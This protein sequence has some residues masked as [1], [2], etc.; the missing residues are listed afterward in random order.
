[1]ADSEGREVPPVAAAVRATIEGQ[2]REIR[3]WARGE[4]GRVEARQSEE[5]R[6]LDRAIACLGGSEEGP[7]AQPRPRPAPRRP[8]KRRRR[9]PAATT[10]AAVRERC[11]AVLRFLRERAGPVSRGEICQTLNLTP[12]T[13]STALSRL[14]D[15]GKAKRTGDGPATR[16]QATAETAAQ[17]FEAATGGT[18]REGTVQGRILAT[19]Q[20]RGWASLDELV[21]AIGVPRD[22]VLKECGLLVKEEEIHMG[23]REG[24]AVYICQGHS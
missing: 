6:R 5:L 19:L 7:S 16:Y 10:P 9:S 4:I 11:E 17:R 18:A 1:M 3:N 12:H 24:R 13:V 8:K 23:R 20:E 21:Q 22:E 14:C 2:A 15:E